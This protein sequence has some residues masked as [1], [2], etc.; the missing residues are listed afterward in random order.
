MRLAFPLSVTMKCRIWSITIALICSLL[1]PFIVLGQKSLDECSNAQDKP[2]VNMSFWEKKSAKFLTDI[3]DKELKI[4]SDGKE[5]AVECLAR[6]DEPV[7]VGILID[8]S[9]SMGG[10]NLRMETLIRGLKNLVEDSH[11][12][13]TYF[14]NQFGVK[15][16][17]ILEET[18]DRS[19]IG[20]VLDSLMAATATGNTAIRDA[21]DQAISRFR[22]ADPRHRVLIVVSDGVDNV[23]KTDFDRLRLRV[24]TDSVQIFRVDYTLVRPNPGDYYAAGNDP[25]AAP[26]DTIVGE[27]GGL[28][29]DSSKIQGVL[30]GFSLIA[31]H[32]R[33]R[34]QLVLKPATG[35]KSKW[36]GLNVKFKKGRTDANVVVVSSGFYY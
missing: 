26:F 7:D 8:A 30:D 25:K 9:G 3:T 31:E 10:K 4:S 20:R 18:T 36:H 15:S 22:N 11:P 33:A 24:R 19:R 12:E 23:S 34:Y 35:P 2:I 17:N 5:L 32:I 6:K 21:V 13:N 28:T 1:S 16:T 14:I 27:S 29:Y